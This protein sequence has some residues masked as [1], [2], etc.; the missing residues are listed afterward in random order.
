MYKVLY[1]AGGI[2]AAL[3]PVPV[4]AGAYESNYVSVIK[5]QKRLRQIKKSV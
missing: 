2:W 5:E 4:I 1:R 3:M